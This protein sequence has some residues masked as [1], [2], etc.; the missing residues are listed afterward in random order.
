MNLYVAR[1]VD[2]WVGFFVCLGLHALARLLGQPVPPLWATTPPSGDPLARPRHVLGI[3][4][5]GLG[6]VAMILPVL[7]ELRT[8]IPGV[9]VD[10][11]TLPGNAP[12]LRQSGL[13]TRVLT[14]DVA[15]IWRFARSVLRLLAALRQGH[16]DT[17]LDFEQF[18][19]IS[20]LFAF[21]T[22]ARERVGLNTEGQQRAWLYTTRIA[23]T[24]S[25]HTIDIFRRL[26]APFVA[27]DTP[28]PAW[29]LPIS[30]GDRER[31]RARLAEAGAE[32]RGP[33]VVMHVGT[34]P[35]YDKIAVKRWDTERFAA[36]ADALAARHGLTVVF[37][38]QGAEERTLVADAIARMQQPAVNACDRLDIPEL[39]GLLAE[40]A[41][42]VSNDTS[43]MHLAGIVGTPVVALFG[44][45]SPRLYGPRGAH[46]IVFYRHL[47]C[48]PCLSNYNLKLS[49]CTNPVCMR[50]I[51]AAEVLAEIERRYLCGGG[52]GARAKS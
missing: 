19:K 52:L 34:G 14:V 25:D 5:Y 9:E 37:T 44:P 4:F 39:L 7:H 8:R 6:N 2:R 1:Y 36:V 16:Y 10:F 3:K 43:V 15:N 13:V 20:G 50:S 29:R 17:V 40:S 51:A 42:V 38:G 48:S 31:A 26:I 32:A 49:H 22:G 11:L 41:F 18:L 47:Y 27:A 28:P 30:A 35:N 33:L 46:D 24:D 21:V 23:Y 12:L 45:T